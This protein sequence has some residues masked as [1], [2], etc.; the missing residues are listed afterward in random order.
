MKKSFFAIGLA[1]MM[2]LGT[3]SVVEAENTTGSNTSLTNIQNTVGDYG[4]VSKTTNIAADFESNLRTDLYSGGQTIGSSAKYAG[5]KGKENIINNITSDVTSFQSHGKTSIKFGE[6]V[7][8]N[9]LNYDAK[10]ISVSQGEINPTVETILSNVS[11]YAK[12]LQQIE[13]QVTIDRTDQNNE[14]IDCASINSDVVSTTLVPYTNNYGYVQ[15][16]TTSNGAT[17]NLSQQIGQ[18]N[19]IMNKNQLV[20]INVDTTNISK[21]NLTRFNIK[22]NG[23]TI[24]A[25]HQNDNVN[26]YSAQ[27]VFNFGDYDGDINIS[28][29]MGIIIAPKA[30]VTVSGTSSGQV[31]CNSF[32]NPGG[33]WHYTG[34]GKTETPVTPEEPET[35][36]T[37]EEPETPVLLKSLRL[38]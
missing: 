13:S 38:Q 24:C 3:I 5:Q 32:T 35:P 31:I 6:K 10:K 22:V 30:N 14:K 4:V 16:A 25:S 1:L 21:M 36:V 27:V 12:E 15:S 2:S 23:Q 33:E 18:T 11:G 37:P 26:K 7:N 20:I 19:I 28:E 34:I 29:A 9:S 17:G 8:I